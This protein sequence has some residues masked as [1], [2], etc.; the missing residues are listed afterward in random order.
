MTTV[1]IDKD[2]TKTWFGVDIVT[3]DKLS[4]SHDIQCQDVLYRMF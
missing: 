4:L 1:F 2:S 3:C